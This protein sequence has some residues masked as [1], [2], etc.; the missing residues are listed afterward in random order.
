MGDR[1]GIATAGHIK[2]IR[3][4]G[5]ERVTPIFAQQSTREMA[6]T[7]LAPS[8]VLRNAMKAV[9]EAGFTPPWGADADHLKTEEDLLRCAQSGFTMFTVDPSEYVDEGGRLLSGKELEERMQQALRTVGER[10]QQRL[11]QL[12]ADPYPASYRP[13][14]EYEYSEEALKRIIVVYYRATCFAAQMYQS[15]QRWWGAREKGQFD[16]EISLDE[17]DTATSPLA[18]AFVARELAKRHV[19][20]TGLAPRFVGEFFKGIDYR[21]DLEEFRAHLRE[22]VEL[23]HQL[24]PYKLS[25]HSG[26]DKPSIYPILAEEARGRIHLKTS[27]T[28]YLVALSVVAQRNPGLFRTVV[29]VSQRGFAEG[30]KV[31][32]T[33][34]SLEQ[35]PRLGDV[36]DSD[37]E[38]AYLGSDNNRQV[39]HIAYG[40]VFAIP[41][42][43]KQLIECLAQNASVYAEQLSAHFLKHLRAFE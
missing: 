7:G 17:T 36:A 42:L 37:L 14:R 35:F 11:A 33:F 16:F 4:F 27:G 8:A 15:A 18:H 3:R 22:H 23:A 9:N 24:G 30:K 28:S 13:P 39:I 26:S 20:F 1:L 12:L 2:A 29:G 41:E 40:S 19:R 21:D 31:Y 5:E 6:R 25:I 38:L 10:P 32:H 43:I 34:A